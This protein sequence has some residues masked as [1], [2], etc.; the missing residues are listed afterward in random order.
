MNMRQVLED[1]SRRVKTVDQ[2][3][4]VDITAIIDFLKLFAD[5][6]HHGKEGV[7]FPV[8]EAAGIPKHDRPIGVM[9]VEHPAGRGYIK[10]MQESAD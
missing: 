4:S 9:L 1:M 7:L 3:S 2:I 8:L 10:Q 5:K 6:C